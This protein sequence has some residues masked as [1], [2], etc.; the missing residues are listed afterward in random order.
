MVR[1]SA[2]SQQPNENVTASVHATPVAPVVEKKAAASSAAKK[3]A[4]SVASVEKTYTAAVAAA[5]KPVLEEVVPANVV[6]ATPVAVVPTDSNDVLLKFV[7]FSAK[8]QNLSSQFSATRAEFKLL[9]KQVTR[10][11]R[12][13]NRNGKKKFSGNRQPSGFIKPTKITDELAEF[14][15]KPVGIEMARTEV[16]RE[17]NN[18][19]KLHNLKDPENG[20]NINP[21]SKLSHLLKLEKEDKL[22][23]FNLQKYM[24]H[25]FL[26]ETSSS[27][28]I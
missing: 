10:E 18:Y 15:G 12:K 11:I 23:Y 21:D 2:P 16:S 8:L 4:K 25:H 14:L 9:E 13:K 5:I 28:S 17:I 3:G 7:E 20:R 19:I 24:K 1:K 26:K 27:V 6:T 22:T